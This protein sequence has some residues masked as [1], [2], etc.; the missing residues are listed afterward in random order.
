VIFEGGHGCIAAILVP[1]ERHQSST[2]RIRFAPAFLPIADP[3]RRPQ[4]GQMEKA[5]SRAS[6]APAMR[7]HRWVRRQQPCFQRPLGDVF[8]GTLNFAVRVF[9]TIKDA[10]SWLSDRAYEDIDRL[11]AGKHKA[12][13]WDRHEGVAMKGFTGKFALWTVVQWRL[14]KAPLTWNGRNGGALPS[15]RYAVKAAL[16][17]PAGSRQRWSSPVGFPEA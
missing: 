4:A 1:P 5:A 15:R 11:G 2:P 14:R 16:S 17:L 7:G 12:L 3:L 9:G 10:K 6:V 13:K 8:D